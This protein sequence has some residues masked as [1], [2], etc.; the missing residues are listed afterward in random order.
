MYRLC[1]TRRLGLCGRSE[2]NTMSLGTCFPYTQSSTLWLVG[3]YDTWTYMPS[4]LMTRSTHRDTSHP[5]VNITNKI[6][7]VMLRKG[8]LS[9][10]RMSS[11]YLPSYILS[12]ST[13]TV[14]LAKGFSILRGRIEVTVPWVIDGG[15]YSVVRECY[16]NV[17][18]RVTNG[19]CPVFGDSGNWSGQFTIKS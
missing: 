1:F 7:T 19:G 11:S 3:V 12:Q 16:P 18:F 14:I 13:I 17:V 15:D 6:G 5:P 4:M 2:R 8:D 9:T 10:P